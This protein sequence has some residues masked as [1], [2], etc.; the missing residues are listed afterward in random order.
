VVYAVSEAQ[1]P[2]PLR[3][4]AQAWPEAAATP[5]TTPNLNPRYTFDQFVVGPS[6]RYAHAAAQAV[7]REPGRTNPLVIYGGVGLGKTHLMCAIGHALHA[8]RPRYRVVYA[9]AEQFINEFIEAIQKSRLD[10]FRAKY[11]SLDCFLLD[12]VQFLIS[13]K[14]RSEE[15]FT[16]TFNTLFESRKQIV[17]TSDRAPNEMSPAEKR[18]I[19]RLE[20]GV[21][22]DIKPPDLDTRIAIL[23]KKAEGEGLAVPDDVINFIAAN[24]R[25]N[26][27]QLEG[28]LS[29]LA[30]YAQSANAAPTVDMVKELLKDIITAS[31]SSTPVSIETIQRVVAQ[32]YSV[33]VRD[34]KSRDR[35]ASVVAPRQLAMYLSLI[36]T[37]RST[38][39][40]GE[41]FGG[42][43]HSTV[44]H[45]R[46]KIKAEIESNPYFQAKVNQ[47]M[48]EVR[49]AESL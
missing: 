17:I 4:D 10:S 5:A 35:T 9:T 8:A 31:E 48:A 42:K 6:N 21:V 45:A 28:S 38:T 44:I 3:P 26:I 47:I 40:V 36:M 32:H 11:R 41:S 37:R 49:A 1:Q 14:G 33:D 34:L 2:A 23:R 27:R 30:M 25:A 46:D 15:E 7:T 20:G 19:S 16:H 39:E 24:V 22:T 12:D 13:H 29:R 43:D 18:L